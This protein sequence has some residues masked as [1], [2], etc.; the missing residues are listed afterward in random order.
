V[1]ADAMAEVEDVAVARGR[2]ALAKA[3]QARGDLA[4]DG[5]R[6]GE[7]HV[8]IEVALERDA[9]ADAATRLAEVHRPVDA[10]D[11]GA[12]RG[13]RLEPGA[14]ALGEDDVRHASAVGVALQR[15]QNARRVVEAEALE[16]A[17]REHPAPAVEDHHRLRS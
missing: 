4:T 1:L 3:L 9:V 8:R 5:G 12:E 14:A 6:T 10:D 7:Q 16:R 13:D 2:I 11:I 15:L 17:I